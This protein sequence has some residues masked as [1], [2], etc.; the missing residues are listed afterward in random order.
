[1]RNLKPALILK[2]TTFEASHYIP[3][4]DGKCAS[5]HGH[6]YQLLNLTVPYDPYD[7]DDKGLSIDFGVIK[8]KVKEY[9]DEFWDHKMIIPAGE[10]HVTAWKQHYKILNMPDNLIVMEHTTAEAIAATIALH[11]SQRL[12][13]DPE[14][15]GFELLETHKQGVVW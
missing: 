14:E 6:S 12:D 1:M 15:I 7:L 2:K 5:V 8:K 3:G 9:I 10:P 4:Y 13:L 11:L